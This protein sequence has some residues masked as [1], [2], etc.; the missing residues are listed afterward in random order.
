MSW[1]PL[2]T[3]LSSELLSAT[4]YFHSGTHIIKDASTGDIVFPAIILSELID[5][6]ND[7]DSAQEYQRKIYMKI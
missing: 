1:D 5:Y 3:D 7:P 6:I 4:I 2:D